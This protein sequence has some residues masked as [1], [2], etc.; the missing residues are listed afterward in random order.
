MPT[1]VVCHVVPETTDSK[2]GG[3]PEAAPG[4]AAGE[5]PWFGD[6]AVGTHRQMF[7][8]TSPIDGPD[9][10][11]WQTNRKTLR[12]CFCSHLAAAG[13]TEDGSFFFFFFF[14]I[15]QE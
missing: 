10:P 9:S 7:Q 6:R 2:I 11:R 14:L 13:D 12:D 3:S 4:C 8:P 15:K 1:V 5:P